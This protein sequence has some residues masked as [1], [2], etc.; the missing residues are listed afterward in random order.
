[1]E[2]DAKFCSR[3]GNPFCEPT[4]PFCGYCGHRFGIRITS[5]VPVIDSNVSAG[6]Q[7]SERYSVNYSKINYCKKCRGPLS[8]HNSVGLCDICEKP[9]DVGFLDNPLSGIKN[10]IK[11]GILIV[12][13]ICLLFVLM[14]MFSSE[15]RE[16]LNQETISITSAERDQEIIH[17]PEPEL[18]PTVEPELSSNCL[19][20]REV[21]DNLPSVYK[22]LYPYEY[23][24]VEIWAKMECEY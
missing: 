18:S 24:N 20:A 22:E 17:P 11:S 3:C 14:P 12:I 10:V 23:S 2:S 21:L 19:S 8:I 6:Q 9:T 1:M 16:T 7:R 15:E 4:H 5:S 13:C